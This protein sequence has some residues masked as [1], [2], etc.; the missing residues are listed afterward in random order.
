MND[1]NKLINKWIDNDDKK[2]IIENKENE[3][4]FIP[5]PS[6]LGL[7]AKFVPHSDVLFNNLNS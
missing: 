6:R 1:I 5:R 3:N 7:G 4:D 2:H